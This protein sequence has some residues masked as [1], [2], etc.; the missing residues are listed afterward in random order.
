MIRNQDKYQVLKVHPNKSLMGIYLCEIRED[1][2]IQSY[3]QK[4]V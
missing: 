3:A 2:I 4:K 1:R